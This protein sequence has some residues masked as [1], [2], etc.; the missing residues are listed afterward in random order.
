MKFSLLTLFGLLVS[1]AA[2][3]D[4]KP[5]HPAPGDSGGSAN[6]TTLGSLSC[7]TDE[8]AK[9]DG[10]QWVCASDQTGGGLSWVVL[11][12]DEPPKPVGVT[13]IPGGQPVVLVPVG[14]TMARLQVTTEWR[15][16]ASGSPSISTIYK[17]ENCAGQA[18]IVPW[19]SSLMGPVGFNAFLGESYLLDLPPVADRWLGVPAPAAMPVDILGPEETVDFLSFVHTDGTCVSSSGSFPAFPVELSGEPSLYTIYPPPYRLS[20]E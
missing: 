13:L 10:S 12:S 11:D 14:D 6:G 5:G 17:Q 1:V 8:I 2:H 20:L 16:S 3:A 4:H 7:S 9:F 15:L 18:Y 19:F